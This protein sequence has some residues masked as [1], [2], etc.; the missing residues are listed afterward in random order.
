MAIDFWPVRIVAGRYADRP[1][2]KS[3]P[4]AVVLPTNAAAG[5]VWQLIPLVH[6]S[7][8]P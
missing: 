4:T 7:Y 2:E 6:S 8:N 1:N 5:M 3:R